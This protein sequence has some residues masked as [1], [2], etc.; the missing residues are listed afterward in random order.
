MKEVYLSPICPS[1]P[2]LLDHQHKFKAHAGVY[3]NKYTR[4]QLI[5]F[6][7]LLFNPISS[8]SIVIKAGNLNPGNLEGKREP[9]FSE[10][11]Y[12]LATPQRKD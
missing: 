11:P 4:I 12:I 1:V 10:F 3:S 8:R 7:G 9:P 6:S 2:P 5:I